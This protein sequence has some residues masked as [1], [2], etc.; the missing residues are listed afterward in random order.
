MNSVMHDECIRNLFYAQET[1]KAWIPMTEYDVLFV[2][3][4]NADVAE[5]VQKNEE[6]AKKSVGFVRKAIDAILKLLKNIIKAVQELI[7]RCT[8]RGEE[9]DA[10]EA[11]QEQMKADPALKNKK[12]S[13][14]DFKKINKQYEDMVSEIEKNIRM[15]KANEEHPVDALVSKV[16]DFLKGAGSKVATVVTAD[17]ALKMA[18]S[19][20]GTATALQKLLENE[21]SVLEGLSKALGK[22]GA[23]AFK[24]DIDAA[25]KNS[26]LHRLIVRVRKQQ[27]TSLRETIT[28]T[29]RA[30]SASGFKSVAD[31]KKAQESLKEAKKA[32]IISK[33]D[34]KQSK[35]ELKEV[36]KLAKSER[37]D[38]IALYNKLM[39][40]DEVKPIAKIIAKAAIDAKINPNSNKYKE[41][42]TELML[43]EINLD[44]SD[45]EIATKSYKYFTK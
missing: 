11:I 40:I 21:E 12:I 23:N 18:K 34:Y 33:D 38:T 8:L 17:M 28:S 4:E 16:T 44:A 30:F 32:G 39:K 25:A 22:K 27:Y 10:F 20:L 19:D 3:V 6:T 2:A 9:R 41:Q 15:V 29:L 5:N 7:V 43:N 37:M 1:M 31:V 45:I 26:W 14:M 13:V 36:L 35:K 24:K 42:F